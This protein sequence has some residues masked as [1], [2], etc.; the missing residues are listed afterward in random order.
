MIIDQQVDGQVEWY[1]MR[2]I[3]IGGVASQFE[4]CPEITDN[5]PK[6]SIY[7]FLGNMHYIEYWFG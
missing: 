1:C 2:E 7:S 4:V 5:F 3:G 6:W